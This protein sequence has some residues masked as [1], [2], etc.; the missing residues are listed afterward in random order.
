MAVIRIA[1]I[2]DVGN[3]KGANRP[4]VI[5]APEDAPERRLSRDADPDGIAN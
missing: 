4:K 3:E 2:P 5:R 1:H